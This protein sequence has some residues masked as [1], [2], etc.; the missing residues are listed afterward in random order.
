MSLLSTHDSLLLD[1]DGTVWEGG[2]PINGAVDTINACGIPAVFVT[3]NASRAPEEV[4]QMLRDIDIKTDVDHVL[5]S[6]QAAISLAAQQFKAGTKVLVVGAESFRDLARGAGFDVVSSADDAP[7]VVLQGLSK[8][9]GWK[10]LSE[11]ALAIRG[12][13][14][15]YVSNM[16]TSL[17]TERG[18]AV[19][20]GALVQAVVTSTGVEPTSAGK[21]GPEMFIQ[22]AK[23]VGSAKPLAVGDRLDTDILGGNGAAMDTFHVLTGVSGPLALIEAGEQERPDFIG[24]S[25]CDLS[26]KRVEAAPGAQGGFTARVDGPDVLLERGDAG[27]TSIQALRTVLEVVWALPSPPRYIQPRSD[28]AEEAV[29]GWW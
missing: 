2:R 11:A 21:P 4:A 29:Q 27:A 18:L 1:L 22:A 20:N 6:A 25:L 24:Q 5:T 28:A 10:E 14:A 23:M 15:Y 3:N 17:P 26:L 8:E 16:D 19:G 7:E 13:A 12:G 9:L